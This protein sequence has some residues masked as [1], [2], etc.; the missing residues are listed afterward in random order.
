MSDV[1]NKNMIEERLLMSLI[2]ENG[3]RSAGMEARGSDADARVRKSSPLTLNYQDLYQWEE[4]PRCSVFLFW[5]S[6]MVNSIN[7]S[8]LWY[9]GLKGF[10]HTKKITSKH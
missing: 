5:S 7:L 10:A 3:A 2:Y 9:T 4:W 6:K 8:S 1:S